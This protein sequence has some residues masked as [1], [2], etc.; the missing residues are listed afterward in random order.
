MLTTGPVL[1]DF[2]NVGVRPVAEDPGRYGITQQLAD[3]GAFRVPGLRNVALRGSYFHNGSQDSLAHVVDF[4][5]RGGDF[6]DNRDPLVDAINGHI[7]V[8][9]N[10][11]LQALLSART[12]PRVAAGLPPFDRPRLWSEGAHALAEFGAGTAGANALP[13][14][15]EGLGA[16]FVGNGA[17]G[18][19]VDSLAQNV[20]TFLLL[21]LA[22]SDVPAS[23]LGQ[24]VNLAL[25]PAL[26]LYP[27]GLSQPG[28]NGSSY[29]TAVFHIPPTPSVAGTYWLQW[30]AL[31]AAGPFGFVTSNALRF[32]VF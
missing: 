14:R 26:Q 11:Q 31:D 23:V 32:T 9:D 20:F 29:A 25:S 10:L 15:I 7:F 13:L 1:D 19:A 18:V 21:D 17:F 16:P 4:Y 3:R 6:A 27:L 24:N 22:G 30:A 12:D 8:A 5:A 2:R 28:A